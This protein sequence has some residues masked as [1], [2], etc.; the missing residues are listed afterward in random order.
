MRTRA[1]TDDNQAAIMEELRRRVPDCSVQSLAACGKGV[2]DLLVGY[3]GLNWLFE[4][5]DPD[6]PPSKT[7]LTP[8]QLRWHEAWKGQI[9]KVF[10]AGEIMVLIGADDREKKESDGPD[11]R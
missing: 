6:K 5:K 3:T 7:R 10:S 1:R 8:D 9:H 4:L 11:Q 2:P